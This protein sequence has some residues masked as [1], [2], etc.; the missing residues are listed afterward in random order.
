MS[1]IFQK[2][3]RDVLKWTP[4][5]I[6]VIGLLC[7]QQ[8][9]RDIYECDNV[10]EQLAA[11]I[12]IGSSLFALA[13]GLLQSVFD[14][15]PHARS[16]LL[17]RPISTLNIFRGKIAAGFVVHLLAW[18]IPMLGVLLYLNSV[19]PERLPVVWTNILLPAFCCLVSFLFH[20][21]AMWM[22]CRAGRWLGTKCLPLILPCIAV[23]VA[24]LLPYSAT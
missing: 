2:E 4:L 3:L 20:P 22:A 19:G 23:S 10:T 21:A 7:W 5:G 14:V 12:L 15:R 11:M 9:P 17:H 6:I 16:F 8:I 24:M 1:T 18:G 13:L